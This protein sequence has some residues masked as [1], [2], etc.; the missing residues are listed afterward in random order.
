MLTAEMLKVGFDVICERL[1]Y[2]VN[3]SLSKGFFRKI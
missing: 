3:E 2:I 1:T